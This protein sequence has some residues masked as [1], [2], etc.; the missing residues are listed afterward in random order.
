MLTHLERFRVT[1]GSLVLFSVLQPQS[2][3]GQQPPSLEFIF[4]GSVPL[5]LGDR[6]DDVLRRLRS[7]AVVDCR[8]NT[9]ACTVSS[10]DGRRYLG[11]VYF[12]QNDELWNVLANWLNTSWEAMLTAD[13]DDVFR[14]LIGASTRLATEDTPF[15]FA[16]RSRDCS[17]EVTDDIRPGHE[18]QGLKITCGNR[19]LSCSREDIDGAQ[20]FW[21]TESL[22]SS[23]LLVAR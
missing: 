17:V 14:A 2:T 20:T 15:S 3:F 18:S 16:K 22:T 9:N 23:E 1:I 4:L 5:L 7:N 19:G 8:G 11:Q 10:S 21:V 6:K 12:N 13:I